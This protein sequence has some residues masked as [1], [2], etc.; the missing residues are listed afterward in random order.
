MSGFAMSFYE[1][2]HQ[3]KPN[4]EINIEEIHPRIF[5]EELRMS[6][7]DVIKLLTKLEE[8]EVFREA[9]RV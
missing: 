8:H 5:Q 3:P 9:D 6:K 7:E 1:W 2:L 4:W